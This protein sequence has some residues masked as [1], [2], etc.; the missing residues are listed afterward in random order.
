MGRKIS[1]IKEIRNILH[2]NVLVDGPHS[3]PV[4]KQIA[5][6]YGKQYPDIYADTALQDWERE[7]NA[8]TPEPVPN[9]KLDLPWVV[10]YTKGSGALSY[11]E[12]RFETE[13]RAVQFQQL[14]LQDVRDQHFQYDGT[15]VRFDIEL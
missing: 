6:F 10:G 9:W 14:L 2:Q 12:G 11:I 8:S 3:W 5:D 1:D 7:L 4:A 15:F 13:E